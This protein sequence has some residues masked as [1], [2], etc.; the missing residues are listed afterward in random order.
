[1]MGGGEERSNRGQAKGKGEG[2]D[3][4]NDDEI[5]WM[6]DKAIGPVRHEGRARKDDDTRGP[7]RAERNECPDPQNLEGQKDGKPGW[8]DHTRRAEN[9]KTRQ[10]KGVHE[11]D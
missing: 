5:V 6:R 9:P 4:S 7:T 11:H 10:P 3:F 1:A 2:C 8:I